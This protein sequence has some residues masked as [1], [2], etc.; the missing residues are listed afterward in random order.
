[1]KFN[2]LGMN[3]GKTYAYI[4]TMM[5]T[6]AA[7]ATECQNTIRKID[8]SLPTWFVA[9]VAMQI[10]C[11]SIIFPITPPALFVAHIRIGLRF[12]CCAVIFCKPPNSTFEDVSLPVS[13]TPSQP[14]NVPKNG[15]SQ[16]VRVNA[17]PKTASMPEYRSEE[18]TSELQ[19][20]CNLVCRLL[21][22]KK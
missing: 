17:R 18:H 1:M 4:M 20:P 3:C 8:P 15:K 7:S 19:S 21:L 12:S 5:P 2:P 10:D 13:A 9:A 22:E 14:I 16:P 6:I 11:A